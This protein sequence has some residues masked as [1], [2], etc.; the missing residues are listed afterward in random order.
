M[1]KPGCRNSREHTPRIVRFKHSGPDTL[2]AH[3][4]SK[5]RRTFYVSGICQ[6]VHTFSFA[7][8]QLFVVSFRTNLTTSLFCAKLFD[9][10]VKCLSEKCHLKLSIV[11][12]IL[13]RQCTSLVRTFVDRRVSPCIDDSFLLRFQGQNFAS[14]VC[15]TLH[16]SRR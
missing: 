7:F 11:N 4:F 5:V 6:K 16:S 1:W 15:I 13:I 12:L 8:L 9:Q 2:L 10:R 14:S 3:R